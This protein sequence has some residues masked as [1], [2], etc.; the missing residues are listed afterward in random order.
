MR[1][2]GELRA[3]LAELSDYDDCLVMGLEAD[4]QYPPQS[5]TGVLRE[6]HLDANGSTTIW[7]QL[8]TI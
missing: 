3:R 8:E 2:L 4:G 1:T 6:H 5:V 7:I